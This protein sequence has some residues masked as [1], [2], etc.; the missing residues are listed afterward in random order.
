MII[1]INC[2]YIQY[3]FSGEGLNTQKPP[4]TMIILCNSLFN[5]ISMNHN[6]QMMYKFSSLS[7]H[8]FIRN[9]SVLSNTREANINNSIKQI[10]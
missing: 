1:N 3:K 7:L 10:Y 2:P 4:S 8:E 9:F 5:I 6:V